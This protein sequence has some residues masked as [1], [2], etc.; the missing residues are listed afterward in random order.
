MAQLVAVDSE[1]IG[2]RFESSHRQT[3]ISDTVNC[4][5]KTR[6][7]GKEAGN[8]L[9]LK[10]DSKVNYIFIGLASKTPL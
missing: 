2:P 1:A 9:F 6:I 3:F 5:E 4:I 10:I 8:G 7:K